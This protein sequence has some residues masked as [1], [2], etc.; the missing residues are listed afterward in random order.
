MKHDMV[1]RDDE[2]QLLTGL[3]KVCDTIHAA[4]DLVRSFVAIARVSNF[5]LASTKCESQAT[6]TKE[7]NGFA[8]GL[9]RN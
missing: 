4:S 1:W 3:A 9:M 2:V 6:F 8:Q 7:M 5:I